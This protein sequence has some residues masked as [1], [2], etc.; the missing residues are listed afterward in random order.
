MSDWVK[1]GDILVEKSGWGIRNIP[2][3][4]LSAA[5]LEV[6]ISTDDQQRMI[7]LVGTVVAVEYVKRMAFVEVG[8]NADN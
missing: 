1:V 7:S 3:P 2:L 4:V 5:N 8:Q 6:L